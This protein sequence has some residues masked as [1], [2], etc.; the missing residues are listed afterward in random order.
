MSKHTERESVYLSALEAI[1]RLWVEFDDDDGDEW[2]DGYSMALGE[3]KEIA[4]NA[5]VLAAAISKA[6]GS[7]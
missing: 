2:S 7:D 6:E 1:E 4:R 5:F 3:C